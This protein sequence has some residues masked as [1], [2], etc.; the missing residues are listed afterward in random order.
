MLTLMRYWC[1]ALSIYLIALASAA[2]CYAVYAGYLS[3]VKQ[4]STLISF[5]T[6]LYLLLLPLAFIFT[7]IF[8]LIQLGVVKISN[9][10]VRYERIVFILVA[11]IIL[12]AGY[13]LQQRMEYEIRREGYVSCLNLA[14]REF[15]SPTF[16]FARNVGACK[17]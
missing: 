15:R 16:V 3:Q 4:S 2:Y 14:K 13:A 17:R 1:G 8:G 9:T 12:V 10:K 5:Q 11:A 7:H 6:N